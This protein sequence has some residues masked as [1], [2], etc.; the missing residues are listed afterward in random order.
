MNAPDSTHEVLL[1][2]KWMSWSGEIVKMEKNDSS[3][4]RKATHSFQTESMLRIQWVCCAV[5]SG[6]DIISVL[7]A[8]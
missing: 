6:F 7:M 3:R 1:K 5:Q 8:L 2:V 4:K